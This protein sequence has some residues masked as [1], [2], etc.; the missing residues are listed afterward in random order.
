MSIFDELLV[1][2]TKNTTT[3]SKV[4]TPPPPQT[5]TPTNTG[6]SIFD[7]L[8]DTGTPV[9]ATPTKSV[10]NTVPAPVTPAPLNP[11]GE[12]LSV[13]KGTEYR[14]VFDRMKDFT[15]KLL[16]FNSSKSDVASIIKN[17]QK[18]FESLVNK[19]SPIDTT[20]ETGKVISPFS[21][22][23][24]ARDIRDATL[25]TNPKG[26]MQGVTDVSKS[27][28]PFAGALLDANDVFKV[29][30]TNKKLQSGQ[31][32]EQEDLVY[33]RDF[34]EKQDALQKRRQ[35]DA[36]YAAGETLRN[37]L[38]FMA[39]LGTAVFFSPETGGSSIAAMIEKQGAI[40]TAKEITK[41]MLADKTTREIMS[42]EL[43]AYGIT[44]TNVVGSQAVIHVP[45]D[46]LNRMVGTPT[47]SNNMGEVKVSIA[48]D[49]QKIKDAVLNAFVSSVIE[50]SSEYSGGLIKGAPKFIVGLLPKSVNESLL[51]SAIVKAVLQKNPNLS[52]NILTQFFKKAGWNGIAGEMGEEQI[53]NIM[54]G[55]AK[56][57]GISDQ[58]F[59]MP[60]MKD[61]VNQFV[62][63]SLMGSTIKSLENGYR[64]VIKKELPNNL[65]PEIKDLH[66]IVD[67]T[68][69][70]TLPPDGTGGASGE[71]ASDMVRALEDAGADRETALGIVMSHVDNQ[72]SEE[73]TPDLSPEAIQAEIDSIMGTTGTEQAG[74]VQDSTD[75]TQQVDNSPVDFS[76][77]PEDKQTTAEIDWKENYSVDY[78][79]AKELEKN[80][81]E[82]LKT[83]KGEIKLVTK[84]KLADA[85]RKIKQIE[86]EFTQKYIPEEIDENDIDLA[87]E[88]AEELAQEV[89][90]IE[91]DF[92][93]NTEEESKV[94]KELLDHYYRN[95]K[96][97]Y[98]T[99]ENDG[100]AGAEA[101]SEVIA[102]IQED[103][104]SYAE[105][106]DIALE[107][108]YKT[109]EEKD[110]ASGKLP[111]QY[112]EKQDKNAPTF[113][114][115]DFNDTFD[116]NPV[117]FKE[118]DFIVGRDGRVAEITSGNAKWDKE[119]PLYDMNIGSLR[120]K[121]IG[122]KK[123]YIE[124][125]NQVRPAT[126][127]EVKQAQDYV[128]ENPTIEE[129]TAPTK[130][131]ATQ[132][133]KI[134]EV[135]GKK[136]KA[137]IKEIA[138]ATGIL[139]PN[140][141]RILGVGAKEGDFERVAEGVYRITDSKGNEIAVIIPGDAI[142]TLPQLAKDGF[143]ADMVF[144]DIPYETA[145]QKG[146]KEGKDS[147]RRLADYNLISPKDFEIVVK[148]VEDIVRDDDTPVIY[149]YAKGKTSSKEM[150][151]YTNILANSSFK[152]IAQ[153]D[154]YKVNKD[155]EV[156]NL[157][158]RTMESGEKMPPEGI[159]VFSKSGEVQ[160]KI[161]DADLQ[162]KLRRPT[163]YKTEKPAEMIAKMIEMTTE[164]G[165]IVL[166]PFA[167]SGV[168]G[169][170]AVKAGRKAVLIEKNK[171]VADTI[172]KPRVEGAIPETTQIKPEDYATPEEYIDALVESIPDEYSP[173]ETNDE[174]LQR[175]ELGQ[176]GEDGYL[177]GT[178]EEIATTK[179]K[180]I[181]I[182][183]KANGK[184]STKE[185]QK[186]KA[187]DINVGD[188][189][190]TGGVTNMKS[191]VTVSSIEGRT[192]KFKDADGVEY[193]GLE[194]KL[195]R[196][197]IKDGKWEKIPNTAVYQF[198][199]E[200]IEEIYARDGFKG[201]Q[202]MHDDA[203]EASQK[204]QQGAFGYTQQ[205]YNRA[206]G[207]MQEYADFD[208]E[209]NATKA[210]VV[211]EKSD[212]VD[213]FENY[214]NSLP[215]LQQ[216][217]AREVLKT[218]VMLNGKL[219]TRSEEVETLLKEGY[220][221]K[222][223]EVNKIKDL[224]RRTF[225][226]MYQHE[227]DAFEKKQR[228]A[229]KKTEYG[230]YRDS[231]GVDVTKTQYD[232]A[233]YILD[234]VDKESTIKGNEQDNR[235]NPVPNVSDLPTKSDMGGSSEVAG[236]RPNNNGAYG[237]SESG[238]GL[239]TNRANGSKLTKRERQQINEEVE[240]LL[241]LREY[242]TS[243]DTYTLD[244]LDKM[245]LYS[246]AGGKE[247]VGGSGAGLLNE[248]YTPR[249]V[250]VRMWNIIERLMPNAQTIFE[251]SAGIGKIIND[252]PARLQVDGAEISKV[253]GTIAQILN[254]QSNITIGDFQ[255][256]F[257]DR[258]TNKQKKIKMYDGV[259]GNPPF[260]ERAGFLKGKGE[261]SGINRQEEYFIKRGLDMTNE[262]G[263]LVYVVNSS[264]LKTLGSRGKQKIAE[265][266][267][268]VEAYRLPENAFD[269]TSIGTD[270]VIFRKG[271]VEL[272]S[273]EHLSRQKTINADNYFTNNPMNKLGADM[274]RKNRFGQTEKYIKG[275]LESAMKY[276]DTILPE[277]AAVEYVQPVPPEEQPV[278]SF[279]EDAVEGETGEIK[280]SELAKKMGIPFTQV[281][282]EPISDLENA[283]QN[284][285]GKEV[286][287]NGDIVIVEYPASESLTNTITYG[288]F[289]AGNAD[290]VSFDKKSLLVGVVAGETPEQRKIRIS[291]YVKAEQEY[292]APV[293]EDNGETPY[294][295]ENKVV[296]DKDVT[297]EKR[298]E[299]GNAE[300]E[301]INDSLARERGTDTTAFV[302]WAAKNKNTEKGKKVS[303]LLAKRK[304]VEDYVKE[305]KVKKTPEKRVTQEELDHLFGKDKKKAT[306]KTATTDKHSI[307]PKEDWKKLVAPTTNISNK[308]NATV[309]ETSMLA[310]IDR[311][312][313]I[314]NP[315]KEEMK[316][317]NYK[318]G[319]YYPDAI[320]FAREVYESIDQLEVDK[321][322]IIDNF[323][324]AQYDKQEKGLTAVIP[325][326]YP[327]SD[328]TFDPKD[329]FVA[330]HP[331][332]RTYR[333]ATKDA[334][335]LDLFTDYI[336]QEDVALT[337]EVEK[338]DIIRYVT[339]QN[340]RKDT[341]F[342]RG[343]IKADS[344]RLFNNFIKNELEPEV[345]KQ[346]AAKFNREKNGYVKPNYT[347]L[348]VL[349]QNMAKLF[350][351]NN[352]T[353]SQTQMDGISFLVN[354]GTGLLAW[355][356][357]V[358]KTL[359]LAVST[360]A[361][362]D[363]GWTKRP[364][365]IVPDAT[366]K[367]TWIK[368]IHDVF[369]GVKI[370]NLEGLQA[371]VRARLTK[372]RGDVSNWIKDGEITIITHTGI[373]QLG[374]KPEEIEEATK[375]VKDAI[376]SEDKGSTNRA[377]EKQGGKIIEVVGRA[378]RFVT[379]V[380]L[381]DLG[382]D[383]V[384]VDEIHNFRK[385]F[386]GV[387]PEETEIDD[388]GEIIKIKSR[389]FGGTIGG[390]PALQAQQLFLITQY[391]QKRNN[392][393][394]VFLASATPI[395]NQATEV[396]NIL[397]YIARDRM[398]QMGFININDFL[399][400]F[401]NYVTETDRDLRGEPVDKE[402]MMS[403][404]NLQALQALIKE[405]FDVQE[406][407]TLVRPKRHV[408]TPH[409]QMGE[410]Q[411]KF[412]NNIQVMLG[413]TNKVVDPSMQVEG[414][415]ELF[416]EMN[417]EKGGS[418]KKNNGVFLEAST[419][420]IANS[421]S[422]FFVYKMMAKEEGITFETDEHG[423]EL[424]KKLT[425]KYG[426]EELMRRIIKES[427]K[428]R[429]ALEACRVTKN[430][431]KTKDFSNFL[432]FGGK[433]VPF[434][435]M[436]ARY[437]AKEL[438]YKP[439]EVASLSGKVS[440]EEKERIKQEFN[441][442][443]IK[444]L[445]GG[446]QT[447]EGIDLQLNGLMTINVALD[448][449]PTETMQVEGRVWRQ[450]NNRSLAPLI[451]P[452][453]ENSGDAMIYGKFQEKGGRINDM[454]SYSGQIF[455]TGEI[456]PKE[457]KLGLITDP[458]FK[459]K[460]QISINK[461]DFVKERI[462]VE[463]NLNNL[464]K[465]KAEIGY[466][467]NVIPDYEDYLKKDWLSEERREEYKKLLT[468]A[469]AKLSRLEK[470]LEDK[471]IENIDTVI[472][473]AIIRIAEI[474]KKIA[475]VDDTLEELTIK[476]TKEYNEHLAKR[477]T[478]DEH[479][480]EVRGFVSDLVE[481]TEDEVKA[482]KAKLVAELEEKNRLEAF[483]E[484]TQPPMF[485]RVQ[486]L[487]L[488][489]FER[490]KGKTTVSKQFISDLTKGA[491]MRS[492]EREAIQEVLKEYKEGSTI[493]VADFISKVQATLLPLT[494]ELE[495]DG[496]SGV[497][498]DGEIR[499][500]VSKYIQR[501][502]GSPVFNGAGFKHGFFSVANYFAHTRIEDMKYVEYLDNERNNGLRRVIEIQSDLF[503]KG[504]LKNEVTG[505]NSNDDYMS[506]ELLLEEFYD[507]IAK[508]KG[509]TID[510]AVELYINEDIS[511][512]PDTEFGK[513]FQEK[514]EQEAIN[515]IKPLNGYKKY[516]WERIIQ[517]EVVDASRTGKTRLQFP[518][519]E[520]ALAIEGL[521]GID[522]GW[523]INAGTPDA[524]VLTQNDLIA[525]LIID[526]ADGSTWVVTNNT[527]NGNFVA[528]ELTPEQVKKTKDKNYN[529]NTYSTVKEFIEYML[530][531]TRFTAMHFNL[532]N[533]AS[534]AIHKFYE[535]DV[536]N[537]LV[538]RYG[539]KEII[540][541]E[542]VTW[543]E[544]ALTP[545]MAN[546]P[547]EAFQRRNAQGEI[548]ITAE[549]ATARVEEYKKRLKLKFNTQVVES[550]GTGDRNPDGSLELDE[551]GKPIKAYAVT[552][553]NEISFTPYVR[554]TTPH[555]EVMHIVVTNLPDIDAFE[556]IDQYQLRKAQNGG[557]DFT[558]EDIERIDEGLAVSYE[559]FIA[560][561]KTS[562]LPKIIKD[563]FE[564]LK[565][566][567]DDIKTAFRG[568][569]ADFNVITDFYRRLA[570]ARSKQE[571]E[572][573][574]YDVLHRQAQ[575]ERNGKQ[576]M[577]F[578]F[579][580]A[581]HMDDIR[582]VQFERIK[583]IAKDPNALKNYG[584]SLEKNDINTLEK[585]LMTS[586]DVYL[587]DKVA[588]AVA[589]KIMKT[590]DNRRMGKANIDLKFSEMLKPY[591]LLKGGDQEIVN[592]VLM[593]G[594][595]LG[596]E[597]DDVELHKKGLNNEQ[598]SAYFAVRKAFRVAFNSLT[599]RMRE[600]GANEEEIATF[601]RERAG[602]MPHKWKYEHAV[603]EFELNVN[604]LAQFGSNAE[605]V[606]AL[607]Q[608]NGNQN[609]MEEFKRLNLK[610][611]NMV[612]Y[613]TKDE[614]VKETNKIN[615]RGGIAIQDSLKSTSVDIMS[616][617]SFEKMKSV[618][619]NAK[620]GQE[621][622]DQMLEAMRDL[623]KQKGFGRH[624]I[625][626]TGI[627]GYEQK[628]VPLIIANYFSGFSGFITKMEAGKE[629]YEEL[630]Q[631]DAHR[632]IQFREWAV[633]LIAYDM[634]NTAEF[635]MLKKIAF[636]YALANDMS[637]LLTNATQNWIVGV[638][639]L[640]K[641]YDNKLSKVAGAE[642]QLIKATSDWA[643]KNI[644]PEERRVI[645]QLLKVGRL[646]GEMT[647]ELLGFKNNPL[648][649]QLSYAFNKTLYKTTAFVEQ[650]VN[651][652]PAFLAARRILKAKGLSDKEANEKAL[653]VSDDI[654]FRGG[655]QHRP[656]VF[657]G[658]GGALL[659]FN[660]YIR[661]F[662]FNLY[663]DLSQKEFISFTKKMFYTF[664]IGGYMALPFA[665]AFLSIIRAILPD[666][667]DEIKDELY[668]WELALKKG[669]IN[670]FANIDISSR[671]N[672]NVFGISNIL[673]D[674]SKTIN[675]LGA[676]GGLGKRVWDGKNLLP[677]ERYLEAF[678]KLMPDF[679]GN[680]L[681]AYNGY[682]YG[683]TTITGNPLIDE[684]GEDFKYSTYEGWIKAI[685]YTP[686]REQIAWDELSKSWKIKDEQSAKSSVVQ[687]KIKRQIREGDIEGA[688]ATQQE[689]LA[690]GDLTKNSTDNVKS[691]L[692][693]KTM[694]ESYTK[695]NTGVKNRPV[696]DAIERDIAKEI[697][698][699]NYT[700][701]QLT[702]VTREFAFYRTFG[703]DD[704][705]ANEVKDARTT[706]E[707]V[708]ALNKARE[709][710][711]LEPFKV[712]F[713]K[714]RTV[715]RYENT[716]TG[717]E[718]TG[719]VLISDAVRKA[720]F[721]QTNK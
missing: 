140:V 141:R 479:M 511:L 600:A 123:D 602:Y 477:K 499:G 458:I 720:Y 149:M 108:M 270:I 322:F 572:L 113:E 82:Q 593:Q 457:K 428:I 651:R 379:N 441:E 112:T 659:I 205:D 614:A 476:F 418:G 336:S 367:D 455:N 150:Q 661:S 623:M 607:H 92:Q 313:S 590:G 5:A 637:F 278:P 102:K 16:S 603:K 512:D 128:E 422:P 89:A 406:D 195:V 672:I 120:S 427:P 531:D 694:Q 191:P 192:V 245:A 481:R 235:P 485:Q 474:D 122:D 643:T 143:K 708:I 628:E 21:S 42:K 330:T 75:T 223:F 369:P 57:L 613:K 45:E 431:K 125:A 22:V 618:M 480:N 451:Y 275:D 462:Q 230:L 500:A 106:R 90:G 55:I 524:K 411:A 675:W 14:S 181:D 23:Q 611:V 347:L 259:I 306:R 412:L 638:G 635:E 88:Q 677:Q 27:D 721:S 233:E 544:V 456:D 545:E 543:I 213:N 41:K 589:D 503:Q 286:Y 556:G 38:T 587:K 318:D 94:S 478:M 345:Q 18:A 170:E 398:K 381:T 178:E 47:F 153:G 48:N 136:D 400:T 388:K 516:W 242:S 240:A 320:Y 31:K 629:Y 37:S 701:L 393:R 517:E 164:E 249:E 483:K 8:L 66:G 368:T 404:N 271:V 636:I 131:K 409:L 121:R 155:G 581:R 199:G 505:G 63:F 624:F 401:A 705:V 354:K 265:L 353:L 216:T 30:K 433:G 104:Y 662:L 135:L 508:E 212:T 712:F 280:L 490:L 358:G 219:M 563:F 243:P 417:T 391:I 584:F 355:G 509:I 579:E 154:Y 717:G 567:L 327:L 351:K 206:V 296:F 446:D 312:L 718:N 117:T 429:Y 526:N 468:N 298:V 703:F 681:R 555:H 62:S 84:A 554:K 578:S 601:E 515:R 341:K 46:A 541:A 357:G 261:E 668:T 359:G 713:N 641:L 303:D 352:F 443:K 615:H 293:V 224:P 488:K 169:A 514:R 592:K 673:S 430:D 696:L 283:I 373:M 76:T 519:G 49:G 679:I 648:Y 532:N 413:A 109:Q 459:A 229:G 461:G 491:E 54:Y 77:L 688:K 362:M 179:K 473:D 350:K 12:I 187:T 279:M 610:T 682:M 561:Q 339:G 207:V 340:F 50:T 447:K 663:R 126:P 438:G 402:V 342:I 513:K 534:K 282:P 114:P 700:K 639:E 294:L 714:G 73:L 507:F 227:Q 19:P 537:Y 65:P 74:N 52:T 452:L 410:L 374:F 549:E 255:E 562:R 302:G 228:E 599:E 29:Y 319:K 649:T 484:I 680:P 190:Y 403:F 99:P 70:D 241:E 464:R 533:T 315:S 439:E 182:W 594:D 334:K 209:K 100:I 24:T 475:E 111:I 151:E 423:D 188:V 129:L 226:N 420:S 697:Y 260:G 277:T 372:E 497:V 633:S 552:Y 536:K 564:R 617:L 290:Q 371:P 432:Y 314:P 463:T 134:K 385:V 211:E 546:T 72:G 571:T 626:R 405:F 640:T 558:K 162:F 231:L 389:N 598:M 654:H 292:V 597:F 254:P 344:K 10:V 86:D 665:D 685:G 308:K 215:K 528:K 529:P 370:N 214:I 489:T 142:T 419:S 337:P 525:G 4:A 167:G 171:E 25:A 719:Y 632:Q 612:T 218:K 657:R 363:K 656:V 692:T 43:K 548:L 472:S 58:G 343:H 87:M 465:L 693:D 177:Y 329:R 482:I 630:S 103:G 416:D 551:N 424:A 64:A 683:V 217:R 709:E 158:M 244:E 323:G 591:S 686:T 276:L 695:W 684:N 208:P 547:I 239:S 60:T 595:E 3:K 137:T 397:S 658:V 627:K 445:I 691:A 44:A 348:P 414:E 68:L 550:I 71:S 289:K 454:L 258:T 269:D 460:M 634:G 78:S 674:P 486:D 569:P 530:Q 32:V 421:T 621:V 138:D 690:S 360:K 382:I 604:G 251:P 165:D 28:V 287:S 494:V 157:P 266:G 107:I 232:Y 202:Q 575:F 655:A 238:N 95:Y 715:V 669:V 194:N 670:A 316:Y 156:L 520:T 399:A 288:R 193:A 56:E 26:I 440:P 608:L 605:A 335:L 234:N 163:G 704:K 557:K 539:A 435:P 619:A 496:H 576:Y 467:K 375:D 364:L 203:Y 568:R 300:I 378:Q 449:N 174:F 425:A 83:V 678:G 246:G 295:A 448:W 91:S 176:L 180:Y 132:K 301:R 307:H 39:E 67:K 495:D 309:V 9:T 392:G 321:K 115:A 501:V 2:D 80:L 247:S 664:L 11:T 185:V 361:N 652:V 1:E 6:S 284:N 573:K 376:W 471:K 394:N 671:V 7:S 124:Y 470:K 326:E 299:W 281:T 338:W 588:F 257:F 625:R 450:G 225:N 716:S 222:T 285:N 333:G 538:S 622:K 667:D 535:T 220:A 160:E 264:F 118:G 274:L 304:I 711:G 377:A 166:D 130:K 305:N 698:G 253:S 252:A 487:T 145:G 380:M 565:L 542:G 147:F 386:Q 127:E 540:D 189:F 469:K 522:N 408:M 184:T 15:D 521:E 415:E 647:A 310:R 159:L 33:M 221:P 706:E 660:T 105:A 710:M 139:E 175:R 383:H 250:V 53:G 466:T 168:T 317:L 606:E 559:V 262:G 387:K 527:G 493:T 324:Q 248:Y 583:E 98:N 437:F 61:L 631:I 434:H 97:Y 210:K 116:E 644:T 699:D 133:D 36:S 237:T 444:I 311:D 268:L 492:G 426:E 51:K 570:Y 144:L 510:E 79:V 325:K 93:D 328:L 256:I 366:V 13:P 34:L 653:K 646:G 272:N 346:I 666:D 504:G 110:K 553:N 35:S 702:N 687:G 201:L 395:E 198:T 297:P 582:R 200:T 236:E 609:A 331:V 577:D 645:E 518:T 183:N 707:K 586:R 689:A 620:T 332:K 186:T 152:V 172:T 442:G 642:A 384:S 650:N 585:F 574:S 453:V 17:Q 365:F 267:E 85:E 436:I 197:F 502:Y 349:V 196:E 204:Y 566:I 146:G 40:K 291:A 596:K 148:A 81:Q 173:N 161:N 263:Y 523:T 356:V 59:T 96:E 390:T 20:T 506:E 616:G 580:T 498:L 273:D 69:T 101:H 560:D 119:D 676:I 396:Y 407:P